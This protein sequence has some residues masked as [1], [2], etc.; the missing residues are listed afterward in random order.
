MAGLVCG[1]ID[2]FLDLG[3]RIFVHLFYENA[4]GDL[5]TWLSSIVTFFTLLWFMQNS[6]VER[7]QKR[8][9]E[10]DK[11]LLKYLEFCHV[12]ES[13][14]TQLSTV[15]ELIKNLINPKTHNPASGDCI[16][17]ITVISKIPTRDKDVIFFIAPIGSHVSIKF[18]RSSRA[19]K[20]CKDC[21]EEADRIFHRV[22]HPQLDE[23]GTRF[24]YTS[25]LRNY[26]KQLQLAENKADEAFDL[27]DDAIRICEEFSNKYYRSNWWLTK[28]YISNSCLANRRRI[29][30]FKTQVLRAWDVAKNCN[31]GLMLKEP[32][33]K[34]KLLFARKHS[35]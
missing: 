18:L 25:S 22:T 17:I 32:I 4:L 10:R 14:K 1:V 19:L 26:T 33:S 28:Y 7:K 11:A 34:L 5:P 3:H 9:E 27:L 21:L 2:F 31:S 30:A 8:N 16:K 6:Q 20:E 24:I 12:F 23:E 15:L 13:E 35:R 29:S